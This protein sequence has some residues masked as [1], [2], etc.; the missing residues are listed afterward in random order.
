M[1]Q[2]NERS[3][4]FVVPGDKVAVIEEFLPSH[5]TF[6]ENGD[7]R[8]QIAGFIVIDSISR[9][10]SVLRRGKRSKVPRR[11]EI[12][13]GQV[14]SIENKLAT[15]DILK[16]GKDSL[17]NPFSGW[18][19]ITGIGRGY[20]KRLEDVLKPGDLIRGRV[21]SNKN[22]ICQISTLGSSFGVI[23]ASCSGCGSDLKPIGK[24]KLTCGNCGRIET[25]KIA[26]DYGLFSR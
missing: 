2:V 10:I 6:E 18:L 19:H 20:V 25:R 13:V 12:V 17:E 8:S 9:T 7:I 11:G 26:D 14:S 21:V 4:S 5:G 16:I 23:Q 15:I 24:G 22:G 3:G 1:N